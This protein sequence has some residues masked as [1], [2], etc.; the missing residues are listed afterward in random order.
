MESGLVTDQQMS[1]SSSY[2][3]NHGPEN[4][5]LNLAAA[6]GKTGAWSSKTNVQNQF[7]QVDFWRN[8]KI[9]KFQTHGRQDYD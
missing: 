2:D 1:A 4:A 8:V 5:M 7:L 9:T 3:K 6:R